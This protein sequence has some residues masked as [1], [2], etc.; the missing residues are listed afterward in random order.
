MFRY[1]NKLKEIPK[2][3]KTVK[4]EI[5]FKLNNKIILCY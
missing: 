1:I 5:N 4:R 3:A 2:K